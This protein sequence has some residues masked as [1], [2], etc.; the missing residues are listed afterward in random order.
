[1]DHFDPGSIRRTYD[2]VADDYA[3]AFADDLS[4]LPLDRSVLDRAMSRMTAGRPVL[5]VGCGPAQ[6]ASYLAERGTP[7]I[8]I[9]VAHRMLQVA[10]Q[11]TDGIPLVAAD[12]RNLPVVAE[13][14][15]GAIIFY[16][17]QYVPRTHIGAALTE[18]RRVLAADG[19]LVIATHLGTGELYGGDEWFGK[20]GG[21]HRR[22]IARRSGTRQHPS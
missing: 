21:A 12:M 13:S 7:S 1:M 5:D 3:A 17:L 20:T 2:T 14:C 6:V 19:V 9:D 15:A 10:R 16:S 11:R 8:G 18:L 22:H 4:N